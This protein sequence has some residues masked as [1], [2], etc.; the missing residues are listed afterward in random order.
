MKTTKRKVNEEFTGVEGNGSKLT[1]GESSCRINVEQQLCSHMWFI[2]VLV[3][4]WM[5]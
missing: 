1:A 2:A 3:R 4:L 5:E